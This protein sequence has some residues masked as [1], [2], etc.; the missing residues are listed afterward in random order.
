MYYSFLLFL[1]VVGCVMSKEYKAV[2]DVNVDQYLGKW[3]QVYSDTFDNVFQKNGR[4][5]T[6]DYGLLENKNI[7]VFN[8]QLDQDGKVVKR[9]SGMVSRG[10]RQNLGKASVKPR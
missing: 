5:A 7:S 4:C 1:S 3:Y 2:D 10:F 8:E 6:A 9:V